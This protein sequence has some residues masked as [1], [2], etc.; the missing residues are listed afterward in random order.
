MTKRYHKYAETHRTVWGRKQKYCTTCKRWKGIGEFGIDREKRDGLKIRCRDCDKA[1]GYEYRRKH[2]GNVR[3]HLKFE[4]R[5]RVVKGVR[6]KLCG[7]CNQWKDEK[8]FYRNRS[9]KDGLAY[10]CIECGREDARER[11][12]RENTSVRKN[13]RYED[14]HRVVDGIREKLCTKCGE[15]KSENQYYKDRTN[16]DDLS[17]RCKKCSYKAAAKSGK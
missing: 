8:D 11:R 7:H 17:A 10:Q 4:Q 1:Y 14:R 12:E 15:W 2:R 5:H 6:Q 9:M 3:E 13:I 16:K